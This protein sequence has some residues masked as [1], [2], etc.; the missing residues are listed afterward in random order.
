MNTHNRIPQEKNEVTEFE[1]RKW[2]AVPEQVGLMP[3]K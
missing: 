1:C 2:H 3:R